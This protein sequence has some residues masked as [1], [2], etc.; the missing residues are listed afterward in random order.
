MPFTSKSELDRQRA[1]ID[2]LRSSPTRA[3]TEGF[4][5]LAQIINSYRGGKLSKDLSEKEA[6]NKTIQQREM[7]Q[8]LRVLGGGGETPNA[9]QPRP[10]LGAPQ[11]GS[12]SQ[13]PQGAPQIL[14]SQGQ[15]YQ[16]PQAQQIALQAALQNAQEQRSARIARQKQQDK[17]VN[18]N[19]P[20]LPSGEPNVDFQEYQQNLRAS[21]GPSTT[22]NVDR[23]NNK[24]LEARGTA[25][26]QA[27]GELE[28]SATSAFQANQAI[29][30]FVEASEGGTAGGA[31]PL[32][33]GVQNF[34]STFGYQPSELTNVA[35]MEQAIGQI[36]GQKMQELG[37]RGLTDQD[38]KILR[39]SLPRVETSQNARVE[40]SRVLKKANEQKIDQYM[41][42]A[43]R[44]Q[45]AFPGRQFFRPDFFYSQGS[46]EQPGGA[47]SQD[48]MEELRQL[49]A[50]FARP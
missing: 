1:L 13:R 17:P 49:E 3:P 37:A 10:N 40:V 6:E 30:R 35:T 45:E 23:G 46:S 44:E 14:P 31:Q 16:S 33:S 41:R 43:Q 39:E 26:A 18:Y 34:L 11:A 7:Q 20:F 29:D 8:L 27:M 15:Q 22:V 47:L 28:K 2:K 12:P 5:A 42:N 24:Y 36:L 25:Q 19:Q 32:V 4:G 21:R 48:E 9:P 50:E 38:M